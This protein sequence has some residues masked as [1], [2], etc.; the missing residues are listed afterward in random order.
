MYA[1]DSTL[2][3]DYFGIP[4]PIVR[5]R[6]QLRARDLDCVLLPLVAFDAQGFRLGMGGGYYDSSFAFLGQPPQ[7]SKPRLIG[8]A[9]GFQYIQQ[10]PRDPWDIT[11]DGVVT[12]QGL[13][14]P[15]VLQV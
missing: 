13:Q 7:R 1:A 15:R 8:L 2:Q 5:P 4:E 10:L 14:R 12:E 9:Y 11:L 3:R 6:Y